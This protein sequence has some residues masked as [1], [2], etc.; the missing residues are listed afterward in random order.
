MPNYNFSTKKQN[1][2]KEVKYFNKEFGDFRSN[3]IDFA[4]IYFPNEYNDFNESSPGMM[5]IEMASYVGDV[6]SYYVDKQFKENLLAYA[7]ERK[8]VVSLAQTMGYK[9]T[10]TVPATTEVDVYHVVPSKL[11]GDKYEPDMTYALLVSEGMTISSNEDPTIS[12]RTI[13]DVNFKYSSSLDPMETTIYEHDGTNPTYYLLKKKAKVVAGTI[14]TETFTIGSP[15]KFKELI[16]SR[17]DITEIIS[18]TDSDGNSWYETPYLAQST[19]FTDVENNDSQDAELS[20]FAGETPYLLKLKKVP[21]RFVTRILSDNRTKIVFG[22]GVSDSPDEEIVPNPTNIGGAVGN[23]PNYLT[24]DFDPVNFLFTKSYGQSP[25]NTT[26]TFTYAYGG[27][28]ETNVISDSLNNIIGATLTLDETQIA[29]QTQLNTVKASVACTN[30]QPAIGGKSGDSVEEIRQ[31]AIAH[32]PTQNR[33]V[34]KEDFIVRTYALPAKYGNVAKA[35]ITQDEQLNINDKVDGQ[36]GGKISRTENPLALNLYTL[37]YDSTGLLVNLSTAVKHNLRTYLAQYRMLT[38]SINIL[39]AYIVNVAVEFEIV[40]INNANKREVVLRCIEMLKQY[41]NTERWQINQPI[42]KTDINYQMSLIEG[43]QNVT[44]LR[45][46]NKAGGNYS[47]YKYDM[48]TA[49]PLNDDGEKGGIIYPSVD[50]MIFEVKYPNS[51]ISGRA[52]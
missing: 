37:G 49:E 34:T 43:V 21:R 15:E 20:Q 26:L 28:V 23:T 12:F 50:P 5:F 14:T 8:N 29:S 33:A 47:V 22:A 6:L 32:F 45:I 27:G 31:N 44:M 11:V 38:D 39:D 18:C 17:D 24:S 2:K 52:K 36:E 48:N 46:Y 19:I 16:L 9:P 10:T 41:F 51:D 3:L 13:E 42:V 40:T 30:P 7:E 1:T 35:Y 25:S 4:K